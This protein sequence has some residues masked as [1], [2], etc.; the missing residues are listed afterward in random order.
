[1]RFS[2]ITVSY[3][4]LTKRDWK[5]STQFKPSTLSVRDPKIGQ[6][7]ARISPR[8]EFHVSTQ[9]LDIQNVFATHFRHS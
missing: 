2:W 6:A 4:H 3:V 8:A 9:N 7:D 5:L 1:M